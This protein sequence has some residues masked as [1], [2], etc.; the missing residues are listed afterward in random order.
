[1]KGKTIII[2]GGTI[3]PIR[4]HLSLCAP[5]FGNTAR[6]IHE[7][8]EGSELVLT[9]MA[10]SNN[11]WLRSNKDLESYIDRLLED[12]EVKAIFMT[13]AVC[14]FEVEGGDFYG[15]RLKTSEGGMALEL[16]PSDKI[17]SKIRVKR[18][19]IFLVGFKTTTGKS[20][21]DQFLIGLEM[22]KRTKCNLVLA[23][24]TI[25]RKNLILTPEETMY[26]DTTDRQ[27]ALKILV[28]IFLMRFGATYERTKFIEG[29]N[30][31]FENTSDTFIRVISF[32][33]ENGGFIENNSNGFTPGHFCYS[34]GENKFLSSQRKVN[35]NLALDAGMSLV[36]VLDG[37][38]FQ[39]E[40]THK[41]SVGARSQYL[42][43][44]DNPEHGCIVHTHNPL[45][46]GSYIHTVPQKPFQCGSLEC[47]MNTA[48]N[49]KRYGSLKAVY[50]EKHGLNLMFKADEDPDIVINF[51]KE[52]LV[53]GEKTK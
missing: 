45:K 46:E 20:V 43:L 2:G 13:S 44:R 26:G 28:D 6:K 52:H 25:T 3:N 24:D 5:A 27:D 29:P 8:V 36:T 48:N 12:D 16:K 37:G 4:N 19:D 49:M 50:L 39:V 40:G 18:P 33:I 32:L 22:M 53:L 38:Q 30:V 47:G 17:I 11:E 31:G 21:E 7:M 14:D 35:H 23:N 34:I 9:Q 41:A 1:M 51:L 10:D 15:E 42:L